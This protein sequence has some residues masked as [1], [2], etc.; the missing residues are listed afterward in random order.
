MINKF[1][2]ILI[3]F[4]MS[5]FIAGCYT[6]FTHPYVKEHGYSKKVAIYDD[7][8]SCHTS[9]ELM[10]M[11]YYN[12]AYHPPNVSPGILWYNSTYSYP[13]WYD[14]IPYVQVY[15]EVKPNEE[16]NDNTRLRN[17]DSYRNLDDS[18][19]YNLPSR[20]SGSS[21]T[22]SGSNSVNNDSD[23]K[24]N[25]NKSRSNNNDAPKSRNNSGERKR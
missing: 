13:W 15:N 11:N 2:P 9:E 6:V 19:N 4:I 8:A 7:C 12:R 5:L 18:N 14:V 3:F 23:S 1:K 24:R 22:N 25:V 21:S 10:Y 17:N 20:S 16:R